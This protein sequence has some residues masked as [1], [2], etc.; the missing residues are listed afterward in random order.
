MRREVLNDVTA[1][2]VVVTTYDMVVGSSMRHCL[3]RQWWR[4]LVLDEGH[5]IKNEATD[6]SEA[7]RKLRTSHRLLLSGT[8]MQNNLHELWSLLNFLLPSIFDDLD[9]FQAWFDFDFKSESVDEKVLQGEMENS[10]V[11]IGRAHV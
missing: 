1:Y 11:K 3:N 5:K 2:D 8:P 9:S 6:V 10:V 7:C 4:C